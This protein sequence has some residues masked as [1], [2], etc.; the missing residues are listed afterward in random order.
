MIAFSPKRLLPA[1]LSCLGLAACATTSGYDAVPS[2]TL[3][4][5][6][7]VQQGFGGQAHF[8]YCPSPDCPHPTRKFHG[9][10][11]ALMSVGQ[12]AP[13]LPT[14]VHFAHG[15]SQLD[16]D[17]KRALE[18]ARDTFANAARVTVT[19]YTDDTGP[20]TVNDQTALARARNV[21]DFLRTR[22]PVPSGQIE[23]QGRGRCCYLA[24]NRTPQGR[25]RNRR[26]EIAIEPS[27]APTSIP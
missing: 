22:L 2:R 15:Q 26:V 16:A 1:G 9:I 12:V 13:S 8:A 14:T 24:S 11:T 6:H 23:T 3:P 19:G 25:A 4:S 20:Q 21:A 27:P 10:P 18:Q 5:A 7:L 17:A